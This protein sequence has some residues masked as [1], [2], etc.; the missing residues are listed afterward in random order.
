MI[1]YSAVEYISA[2]AVQS[3]KDTA[4]YYRT[5]TDNP[6]TQLSWDSPSLTSQKKNLRSQI[7]TLIFVAK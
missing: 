6:L 4:Q 2:A 3:F 7:A 5:S 1:V